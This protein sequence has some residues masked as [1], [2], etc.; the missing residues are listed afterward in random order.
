MI[1]HLE[2]EA[3][4]TETGGFNTTVRAYD[5]DGRPIKITTKEAQHAIRHLFNGIMVAMIEDRFT[6]KPVERGEDEE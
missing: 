2:I 3:E 6:H 1:K 5:E 4:F